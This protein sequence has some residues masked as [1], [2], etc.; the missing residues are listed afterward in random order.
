MKNNL[1]QLSK[2]ARFA[3]Q[4]RDWRNVAMFA[5]MI[6]KQNKKDPEGYFLAGLVE[7]A[8][9]NAERAVVAFNKTLSLDSLRYDAAVELAYQYIL[10]LDHGKAFELLVSHEHLL[11]NSPLYL[12]MA[13][14]VFSNLGLHERAFT[15]FKKAN[16]L[17]PG[18][19]MFR[20]NLA[21]CSVLL[22]KVQEA[23][24]IYQSLLSKYP[25][26]Q[27]NHYEL[28]KL[29][30][31]IDPS[32][33]DQ[34]KNILKV[35]KLPPEKNIFLYYAIGKELE[36]LGRWQESFH[37]YK[38]AGS[39]ILAAANY[40]VCDDI[41]VI[42]QVI[43]V[44]D[45]DW[46]SGYTQRKESNTSEKSPIFIVGLPRTGT[47]LTERIVASHSQVESADETF[48]M[49]MAIRH[50]C[51][52][53][54][55]SDIDEVLIDKASKVDISSIRQKYMDSV[56]YRLTDSPM[57]IDKFPT[58]FLYLGFIAKAFPEARIIYLKRNP[59]DACFAMFKQSFFKFAYSL[60][61]LGKY[62]VAHSK[63]LNHWRN[64]IGDRLIEV[65]YEALVS[66]QESQT[67]DLLDKLALEFEMSCMNFE[68]N[69]AASATASTLQVREKVHT[70]SVNKWK[71]YAAELEPLKK[72]LSSAGVN[73]D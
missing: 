19:D 39:T 46:L 3:V 32:H 17:Q 65:S 43:K 9:K 55:I 42:E 54:G 25:Q 28:S 38:Q 62:Y 29:E 21:G 61:D 66:N 2:Q 56:D 31:A 26:H 52:V 58:N 70:R 41:K 16:Q 15:L 23:K 60:E 1:S 22:G 12:D 48:F 72:H 4:Q 27:Q 5:Q 50:A 64:V 73:I 30:K 45:S 53:G 8:S 49:Q 63:L 7:K 10:L 36:D 13:A 34:M 37:Y 24:A 44:C 67:R 47:T 68:Q 18:L 33:V 69:K 57:F 35:N 20:A 11:G 51:G 71:K 6:L 14:R 40:D 59:M